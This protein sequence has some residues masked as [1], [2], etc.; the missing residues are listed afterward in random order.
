MNKHYKY[1]I[2]K[3]KTECTICDCDF[4][5]KYIGEKPLCEQHYKEVKT[6]WNV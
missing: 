1:G 3:G 5:I 6:T 4:N 2:K